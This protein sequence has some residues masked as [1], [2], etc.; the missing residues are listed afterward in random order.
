MDMYADII[1]EHYK[2][3]QNHGTLQN[4][5]VTHEEYN[6][7]CGDKITIQLLIEN[8]KIKDVKFVGKGCAISIASTSMLTDAIKNQSIEEIKK[9]DKEYILDLL[10]VDINPARM[11]CA[12]IGMKTLKLA[13]YHFLIN[14][15]KK[16][17]EKEFSVK[18]E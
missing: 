3:P 13:V 12:T 1:L 8:D 16:V 17:S 15:H 14:N 11:K 7:L 10:G 18:E 5:S 9:L 6:P 2:H 4:A